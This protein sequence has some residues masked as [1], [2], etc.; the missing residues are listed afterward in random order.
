MSFQTDH[1]LHKHMYA[2]PHSHTH[3]HTSAWK[4]D[5][6][7]CV[8][9]LCVYFMHFYVCVYGVLHAIQEDRGD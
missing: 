4:L 6:C 7:V 9:N 8:G 3:S 2:C 5:V 1:T